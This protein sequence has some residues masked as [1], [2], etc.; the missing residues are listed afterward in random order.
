ME[1]PTA[2]HARDLGDYASLVRRRWGW[3]AGCAALGLL[4][5]SAFL[6]VAD[7]TYV[8]QARVLV[9]ATGNESSSVGERTNSGINLDTEAQLVKSE[10]VAALAARSLRTGDSPVA[11]AGRVSVTVPPNTTV[12]VIAF[13]APTAREAQRGAAAFADAYLA[14]R[15]EAAADDLADEVSRLE[16]LV[17]STSAEIK[18]T[19]DRLARLTDTSPQ[20]TRSFLLAR[21][22]SLSSQLASYNTALAPL[23]GAVV[24]P[25][26][27]IGEAQRPTTPVDP[28]PLLVLPS[29]LMGGLLLGVGLASLRER[30]DRRIHTGAEVERVFGLVPVAQLAAGK[31]R[32]GA[33]LQHD[34]RALY[35]TLRAYGPP[36]GHERVLVVG[37]DALESAQYLSWSLALVAARS[38]SPACYVTA[39]DQRP[40]VGPAPGLV[41]S[42]PMLRVEDYA[43]LEVLVDGE[44]RSG[45]LATELDELARISEFLVLDLP[46]SDPVVDIP[47]LGRHLDLAVVVVR[48]G[49][50]RRHHLNTVLSTLSKS[51]VPAVLAVT[52]DLGRKRLSRSQVDAISVLRGSGTPVVVP[53][54][55]VV[56]DASP[57][58]EDE[59]PATAEQAEPVDDHDEDSE[60]E[61]DL[62][63]GD[64]VDEDVHEE[65][66]PP[67]KPSSSPGKPSV[68]VKRSSS[69]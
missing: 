16:D 63:S 39:P 18:E 69:R 8:S 35:H 27:V 56:F 13:E 60:E 45:V 40:E 57:L 30:L 41:A 65:P 42:T 31:H 44:L 5:G 52:L 3:I 32:H 9:Q 26:E 43:D 67:R 48:L 24:R 10:P 66:A 2:A 50:T 28:N 38:G 59:A 4:L 58:E 37:P 23:A 11:L 6:V 22:A 21:R 20:T 14:N 46:T 34:V 17:A 47:A 15:E 55:D 12:M 29:A 62:A 7:R 68:P 1:E 25:G 19:N 53:G 51:G 49:V 33:R 54:E 36:G 64:D 61:T